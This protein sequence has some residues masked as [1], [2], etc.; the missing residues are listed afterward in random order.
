MKRYIK[1]FQ[2]LR[3]FAAI[4]VF[5]EHAKIGLQTPGTFAVSLFF[6]LSGFLAQ[7]Q[8]V[9]KNGGGET[10]REKAHYMSASQ[11]F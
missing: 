10:I 6:V 9:E 3:F 7:M 8:Y 11:A 2:G 4:L 1:S 5:L